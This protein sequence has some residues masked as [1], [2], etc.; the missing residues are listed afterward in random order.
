MSEPYND[1][2]HFSLDLKNFWVFKL[3]CCI[4]ASETN[5]SALV[6][7]VEAIVFGNAHNLESLGELDELKFSIVDELFGLGQSYGS[8]RCGDDGE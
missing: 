2:L 1:V 6:A 3:I 4:L 8:I 5:D 7:A